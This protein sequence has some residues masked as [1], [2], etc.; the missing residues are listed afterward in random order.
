MRVGIPRELN[1]RERRVALTPT[2]AEKLIADGHRVVVE[3]GAGL[4]AGFSDDDYRDVGANIDQLSGVIGA[5]GLILNIEGP[6]S[7]R[8]ST[9]EWQRLNPRHTLVALHDPLWNADTVATLAETGVTTLALELMPRITRAQSMDVLS[10]MATV[11]GYEAVLLA[12][13]RAPTMWPMMM[14][15]AGTIPPAKVVVLGAG[16]AGLQAIATA[17]RLGA[18][19]H[20]YDIRPAAAEQIASLGAKSIELDLETESAEDAG[21]YAKKQTDE[22][23]KTQAQQLLP[24]VAEADAVITT[25]SIPGAVSP[26]L[27]TTAMVEAMKP[28]AV[29]VDLAA[30]RGGNCRLCQPDEEV[31][32]NG[33]TI[34]GPT[35]LTSRAAA[36][37]SQMFSN[38]LV[39]LVR[40]L[41]EVSGSV[42]VEYDP[43]DIEYASLAEAESI[44]A[45]DFTER[46]AGGLVDDELLRFDMNDEITTGSLIT[47]D[48]QV[49]HPR[50]RSIL[51]LDAD[52]QEGPSEK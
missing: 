51:K 38:N 26:E 47:H 34:F 9:P 5:E 6:S 19:V 7:D 32:H 20:A 29:I 48:G 49:V 12:A 42:T 8:L 17:R 33:V 3:V 44:S 21:G 36:T 40:H 45:D 25:A 13:T 43:D 1:S 4:T 23:N 11:A 27:I 15:A 28:G 22:T 18:I 30:E 39:T 16:V 35:D 50:V 24:Y 2:G 41:V 10:S 52:S 46:L 37:S 14:T 31:V